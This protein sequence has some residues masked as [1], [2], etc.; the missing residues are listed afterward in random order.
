MY[1]IN[2]NTIALQRESLGYFRTKIIES[3][4]AK[5]SSFS[6]IDILDR[7]C[8]VY[9]SSYVGRRDFA[10]YVLQSNQKLPIPV[11]PER[12]IYFMPTSSQQNPK[13]IW[14]SYYHIES[15]RSEGKLTALR[16]SNQQQLYIDITYKQFD[17]QMKR[18]SHVIAQIVKPLY[19]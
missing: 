19:L 12:G 18:T 10:S 17:N 16:L 8:N 14:V 1:V 6:I 15:Y 4:S 3:D 5:T 9:G 2:T 11:Y 13:C 7:S